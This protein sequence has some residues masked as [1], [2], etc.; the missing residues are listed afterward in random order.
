MNVELNEQYLYAC[1][2][3]KKNYIFLLKK[4]WH[5]LLAT[6]FLFLYSFFFKSLYITGRNEWG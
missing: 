6:L 1:V 4:K 3:I 5:F 2:E